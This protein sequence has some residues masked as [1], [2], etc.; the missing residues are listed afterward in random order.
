M[1]RRDFLDPQSV[2]RLT[3]GL[4]EALEKPEEKTPQNEARPALLRFA[5]RVMASQFEV[6]LPFGTPGAPGLARAAFGLLDELEARLTVYRNSSAISCLNRMAAAGAVPLE[7]DLFDLL[8]LAQRMTEETA[9]AFDISAGSLIKAW[10]FYRGP[11]RVPEGTA[12][13]AA[14]DRSGMQHVELDRQAKS[15]R[16]HRR[17]LEINLGSIGKGYALDRVADCF[18]REWGLKSALLHGGYSSLYAIGTEPGNPAGWQVGVVHP[19]KPTERIAVVH[20]R[21]RAMGTSA[22]TFQHLEYQGRRLGHILDPRTGWP[23]EGMA[24]VSVL[25]P[26]GAQADA[27]ATAFYVLGVEKARAYCESHPDIGAV[28][29]PE[30]EDSIPIVV[31]LTPQEVSIPAA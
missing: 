12:L 21:N 25:A 4:V 22:A 28:L 6:V 19:W 8:A 16:F 18:R 23:A 20:L 11:R 2:R 27:L 31:G 3:A 26:S 9:G 5:R 14:L 1:K 13:Q 29:L 17:G 10:G 7:D 30:G 24:S 15:V